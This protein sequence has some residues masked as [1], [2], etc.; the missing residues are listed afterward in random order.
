MEQFAE[1]INKLLSFREYK[2]LTGKGSV[3]RKAAIAKAEAEYETFN[4]NQRITSDFDREI[5]RL[6]E[7]K[8]PS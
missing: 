3:S 5:Q 6:L 1:S 7:P 4:K 2:I 8:H